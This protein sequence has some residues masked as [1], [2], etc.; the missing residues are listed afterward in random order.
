MCHINYKENYVLF[1]SVKKH[2][3]TPLCFSPSVPFSLLPK[4]A[5]SLEAVRRRWKQ[6]AVEARILSAL[7]SVWIS[8]SGGKEQHAK[9]LPRWKTET[10][11]GWFWKHF[12]LMKTKVCENYHWT[13]SLCEPLSFTRGLKKRYL[14]IWVRLIFCLL[15]L[16][17]VTF[18]VFNCCSIPFLGNDILHSSLPVNPS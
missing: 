6:F 8:F 14:E 16:Q 11:W 7:A 10:N 2:Q 13:L 15:F 3:H 9:F 17:Y 12:K 5:V 18:V 1:V 4:S